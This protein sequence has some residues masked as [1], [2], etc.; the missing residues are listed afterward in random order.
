[1]R[2]HECYVV[3]LLLLLTASAMSQTQHRRLQDSSDWWSL[4]RREELPGREFERPI[5]VLKKTPAE[6]HLQIAGVTLGGQYDAF[7]RKIDSRFG[8]ATIVERGDA[9]SGREQICYASPSG[10]IHLIFEFGEVESI[11]YLFEGGPEWKGSELCSTSPDLTASLSTASGLRLGLSLQ[12]VKTL[13]GSPSLATPD[14]L[15]YRFSYKM[16]TTAEERAQ[17]RRDLPDISDQDLHKYYDYVGIQVD[18]EVSFSAGKLTHLAI[19]KSE[20]W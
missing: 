11:V 6:S 16:K 1:M 7:I 15:L 13:L 2:I 5:K 14:K 17:F 18:I 12:Q 4:V 9:A 10:R 8:Q 3:M 20:G 19:S